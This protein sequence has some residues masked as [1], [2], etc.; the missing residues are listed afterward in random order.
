ML[1]GLARRWH[2]GPAHENHETRFMMIPFRPQQALENMAAAADRLKE[3]S[4]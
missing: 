1:Q 4:S 2:C 3:L